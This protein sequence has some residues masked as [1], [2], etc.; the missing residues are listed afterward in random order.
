MSYHGSIFT[1]N[2]FAPLLF[3]SVFST[4]IS[5]LSA[6]IVTESV[7]ESAFPQDTERD[8][9]NDTYLSLLAGEHYDARTGR[10]GHYNSD[11]SASGNGSMSININ[12]H[13][14]MQPDQPLA[15]NEM[16]PD[17]FGSMALDIPRPEF[18]SFESVLHPNDDTTTAATPTIAMLMA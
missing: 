17:L 4:T 13:F 5:D 7:P 12:R 14:T 16:Y 18:T 8:A 6:Q 2:K 1:K 9:T 11:L 3:F 10:M 15:G